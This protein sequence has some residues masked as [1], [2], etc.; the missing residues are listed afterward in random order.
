MEKLY[1]DLGMGF[2]YSQIK[3]LISCYGI[4]FVLLSK[5]QKDQ[6]NLQNNDR[7]NESLPNT[8]SEVS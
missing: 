6:K 7:T 8:P 1:K 2:L 3:K 5:E 4:I